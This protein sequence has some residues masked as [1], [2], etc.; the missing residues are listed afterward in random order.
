MGTNT[1]LDFMVRTWK[2]DLGLKNECRN[3]FF[4][5]YFDLKHDP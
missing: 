1:N 4:L 5:L 3:Y 2:N